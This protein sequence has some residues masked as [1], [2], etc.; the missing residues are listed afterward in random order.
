MI[1]VAI[2]V[3]CNSPLTFTE[4]MKHMAYN[5]FEFENYNNKFMKRTDFIHDWFLLPLQ[6]SGAV[7]L[8]ILILGDPFTY[9]ILKKKFNCKTKKQKRRASFMKKDSIIRKNISS[10][11]KKGGSLQMYM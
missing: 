4:I 10:A 2:T 5:Y 8:S 6:F 7:F 11:H 1:F 3:I 9:L